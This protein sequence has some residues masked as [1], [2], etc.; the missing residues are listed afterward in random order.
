[1]ENP[2]L[3]TGTGFSEFCTIMPKKS[4]SKLITIWSIWLHKPNRRLALILASAVLIFLTLTAALPIDVVGPFDARTHEPVDSVLVKFSPAGAIL[5]PITALS[6]IIAGAPDM[7]VA[8]ISI[9]IWIICI[10]ACT[11]TIIQLYRNHWRLNWPTALRI[12]L[13]IDFWLLFL[14]L[15]AMFA[16]LVH[17][18]NFQAVPQDANIVLAELQTHTFGSH[19]ALIS[20]RD[21]LRWHGRR[22]C[23]VVAVTD[24]EL[25]DGG[26]E[27]ASLAESD[28]SLPAV[29]PGVEI[30]FSKLGHVIAL[31]PKEQ[32]AQLPLAERNH[33][34]FPPWFHQHCPQGAALALSYSLNS[35]KIERFVNMEIDGFSIANDGHPGFPHSL[36]KEIL[37]TT[38]KH[39]LSLVVWTD[40]HGYTAILRT[41]TAFHIPDANSLS[42]NQ[43]AAAVLDILRRRDQ[44]SITPIAIGQMKQVSLARAVFAPFVETVIYALSLSPSR[45]LA[46]WVWGIALFVISTW[47]LYIGIHPGQFIIAVTLTLMGTAVWLKGLKLIIAHISGQ[48]P[49]SYPLYFGSTALAIGI[50]S[51][52]TAILIFLLIFRQIRPFCNKNTSGFSTLTKA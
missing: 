8:F 32:L 47:L 3:K 14:A 6:H 25:L 31:A 13:G 44:S 29:I 40:W 48:A 27:S 34:P 4:F 39:N 20:A 38:N 46:W 50:A 42:R 15:Y 51:V 18:P 24:H 2:I 16:L 23:S 33:R 35:K 19:D 41:W 9:P 22:G 5:E 21:C 28:N 45:L 1:M 10:I 17:I 43:R 7:L 11:I 12:S 49:Y 52:I 26:L 37:N 36:Q 30:G